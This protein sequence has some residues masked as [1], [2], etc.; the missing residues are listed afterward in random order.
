MSDRTFVID[1]IEGDHAVVEVDGN[2]VNI[3][4]ILLPTSLKEGD[5]ITISLDTTSSSAKES[6]KQRLKRLKKRDSGSQ[7]IDL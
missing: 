5:T 7:S 1:R 6:A 2:F 4:K 3:L